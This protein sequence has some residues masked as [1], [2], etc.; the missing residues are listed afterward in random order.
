MNSYILYIR[1]KFVCAKLVNVTGACRRRRG[2]PIDEPII[3]SFDDELDQ[4]IDAA[5]HSVLHP[6]FV[7]T[8][9]LGYLF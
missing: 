2:F 6:Q 7:P 3:L 5:F 8:R 1:L 9:T 4:E